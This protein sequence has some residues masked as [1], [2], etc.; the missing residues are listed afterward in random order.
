MNKNIPVKFFQLLLIIF[1][2]IGIGYI[3]GTNRI[4]AQWKGYTPVVDIKS[5]A[6]PTSSTL[7][8][9][10]FY[11]VLDRVNNVYYDKSKIDSTKVLYGAISGMLESLEDPYTS[12]F[13]P[14]ENTAFKEQLAGEFSGIGAELGLNEENRVTIVAP[15]DGSPAE[16]AGLKTGDVVV[17]VNGENTGGWNIA[18]AVEKIRGPRGS[19]VILTVLS[20]GASEVKEYKIVRDTI[21]VKSVTSWTKNIE[22]TDKSCVSKE[23]CT[24]CAKIGYIRLSQ[25][26]DKTNDEWTAAVNKLNADV[27]ADNSNFKGIILDLRNN[28]GGYLTDA[29]FIASEFIKDGVIVQQEDNTGVKKPMSVSRR[30]LFNQTPVVV[31]INQGSASASEIVSGALRDRRNVTLIGEKSFGK[32]TIQEAVDVEGGG[33]IHISVAKWLTPNNTWVH[34]TGLEPDIKVEYKEPPKGEIVEFDNQL[35]TAIKELLAPSQ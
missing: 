24:T 32:G 12:F 1:I 11:S 33:S 28:P 25:F 29:V 35:T 19:E 31:L 8:M 16:R 21:V 30:G 3:A 34:K 20:K 7:D 17:E 23:N 5:K 14:K 27:L 26:G 13:P 2:S 15:L 18:Q 10:L 4:S 22:C 9:K 6:P